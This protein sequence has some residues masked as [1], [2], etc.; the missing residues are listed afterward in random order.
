[1]LRHFFTQ[2]L[3]LFA[4]CAFALDYSTSQV[5][6]LLDQTLTQRPAY[7]QAKEQNIDRLRD[8]YLRAD[9]SARV[10]LANELCHEYWSFNTDSARHYAQSWVQLAADDTV[11]NDAELQL[12]Q[13]Y[14]S[15][16]Q[17]VNG[18]YEEAKQTLLPLENQLFDKNRY[19][20]W[21]AKCEIYVWEAQF[22]PLPD[23]FDK[24]RTISRAC[25]DSILACPNL[26][27]ELRIHETALLE[28]DWNARITMLSPVIDTISINNPNL[29]YLANN[30]G[31]CYNF[32]DRLDSA[33][34]YYALSAISDLQQSVR[35]Y[36]SLSSLAMLLY[37]QGDVDRAYRYI[38]TSLE[39]SELCGAQMRTVSMSRFLPIIIQ[40]YHERIS[41]QH[42]WLMF[43]LF[44]L[45]ALLLIILFV[46]NRFARARRR[47][48]DTHDKL[49]RYQDDLKQSKLQVEQ[50]FIQ[51]RKTNEKLQASN[52]SLHESNLIKQTY[53]ASYMKQCSATLAKI[54]NY[55]LMLQKTALT[56][57]YG[58][59]VSTIKDTQVIDSELEDFYRGFD[60]T[61][62]SLFP[63][64]I[65]DFNALLRPEEQLSVSGKNRLST[66][67]RIFALIRLGFDDIDEIAEFLR[68]SVKTI[69]NYRTKIRNK[70]L[71]GGRDLEENLMK[72]GSELL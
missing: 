7:Q 68:Y 24:I 60:E 25:H 23:A 51:L 41:S 66:E 61:F 21:M 10:R 57:N 50:A 54:E 20:Y 55:R 31:D 16:C 19:S 8:L 18:L 42:R 4:S 58:K 3:S 56:S 47:L 33:I 40:A 2:I 43:G 70:A 48:K 44:S 1:M 15:R 49:L 27:P 30:L 69:Y 11:G 26:Q 64:F 17:A 62:L 35:E 12:A 22:S 28:D 29:R 65:A 38:T 6:E 34:Y 71:H 45:G 52:Q 72:I 9:A 32:S 37:R 14:L 53:V 46:L 59:L 67:L 13:I 39:D 5:I 63:T 36:A